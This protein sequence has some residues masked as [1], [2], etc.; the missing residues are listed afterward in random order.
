MGVGS[1]H[2]IQF[3]EVTS[4]YKN[5]WVH[6]VICPKP[7]PFSYRAKDS[8]YEMHIDW[9]LIRPLVLSEIVVKAKKKL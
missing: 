1:Y 7:L 3:R 2:K 8:P 9:Q 5:G 6:F 4:Y